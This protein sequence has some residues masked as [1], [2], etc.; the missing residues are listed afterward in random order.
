MWCE[1]GLILDD[2]WAA[3]IVADYVGAKEAGHLL[4]RSKS[5]ANLWHDGFMEARNADGS[6]AG[7]DAG[8]TEGDHWAYSLTVMVC[9]GLAELTTARRTGFDPT[10]GWQHQ[11]YQLY[12]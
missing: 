1:I 2:D 9:I 5:Y 4:L 10:H 11:L 12:G 8:W 7:P 3:S 6:W